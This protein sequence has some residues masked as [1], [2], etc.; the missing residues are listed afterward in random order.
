MKILVVDDNPLNANLARIILARA[1]HEVRTAAS[2]HE[3]MRQL[4]DLGADCVVTDIN[5][6]EISGIELCRALRKRY[7]DPPLRIVAYTALA[8]QDELSVIQSAGFDAI[9]IKPASKETLLNAADPASAAA[10][11]TAT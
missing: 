3:A 6:P 11:A 1:G 9:V 5:M 7:A 10:S 2:A 4:Q 8:M